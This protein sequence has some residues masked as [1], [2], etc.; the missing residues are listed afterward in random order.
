M[1]HVHVT[2]RQDQNDLTLFNNISEIPTWSFSLLWTFRGLFVFLVFSKM[3]AM[4][5]RYFG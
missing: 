1:R 3:A 5:H 2:D 4:L